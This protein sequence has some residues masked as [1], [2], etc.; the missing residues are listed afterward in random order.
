MLEQNALAAAAASDD[1]DRLAVFNLKAEVV[2][3][4]L[5]AETFCQPP[6]FDHISP[7]SLPMISVRKKFAIKMVMEE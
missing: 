2:E 7:S 6:D 3:D 1:G 5:R 4:Q